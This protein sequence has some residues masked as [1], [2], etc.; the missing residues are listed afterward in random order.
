M[1]E[2]FSGKS[3]FVRLMRGRG[4]YVALAASVL[5]FGGVAVAMLGQELFHSEPG[6]ESSL[7]P[8]E[9]VEQIVTNQP[10]NRTTTTTTATTAP[11]RTTTATTTATEEAELYILPL[12]NTVQKPFSVDAPLYCETM[13]DWRIHTGVDF[14]GEAEQNVKA[15]ANGTVLAIE[16][17]VMWGVCITIDHGVGVVSRYCGVQPSV[18]KGASVKVGQ[19][20]G[21]LGTVPCESAQRPHLHLEMTVDGIPVDPVTALAKEVRY[22]DSLTENER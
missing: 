19:V 18:S 4:V 9:M 1:K 17:D 16:E 13:Q 3:R 15:L 8:D 22:A 21:R 6:G 10:A 20:I 12:S 11:I 14:A 2:T 7:P 5:A